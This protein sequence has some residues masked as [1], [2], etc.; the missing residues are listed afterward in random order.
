MNKI[1]ILCLLS[2]FIVVPAAFPLSY[3]FDFDGDMVWDT[4][5]RLDPPPAPPASSTVTVGIWLD[6]YSCG[7]YDNLLGSELYFYYDPA[8]MDVTGCDPCLA[9][10]GLFET[11][12]SFCRKLEDGVYALTVSSFGYVSVPEGRAK[13]ADITLECIAEGDSAVKAASSLSFGGYTDGFT[14]DCNLNLIYPDSANA[15]VHQ[16]PPPCTMGIFPHYVNIPYVP[17]TPQVVESFEAVYSGRCEPSSLVY[18]DDCEAADVDN[19][20]GQLTAGCVSPASENCHVSVFDTANPDACSE[21][22]SYCVADIYLDAFMCDCDGDGVINSA[23]N[24]PRWPNGPGEGACIKMVGGI[25]IDTGITC[26]D[27]E[28]CGPEGICQMNQEDWDNNG[29]G[30]VCECYADCDNDTQVD[31]Y[32]LIIMKSEFGRTGC[33]EVAC[34]SDCDGD[35]NVGLFDLAI[36]KSQYGKNNCWYN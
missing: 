6:G 23:D 21:P 20:T 36:M 28:S 17:Q 3:Q 32:D 31:I 10:D 24:C 12:L 16:Q 29:I 34:E 25:P 2:I 5:W 8:T 7:A 27:N 11:G 13:L 14:A 1:T 35:G 26:I 9:P 30:D 22:G 18:S 4:E 15:T 19:E 33:N